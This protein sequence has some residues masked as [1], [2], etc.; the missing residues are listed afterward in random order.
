MRSYP[1]RQQKPQKEPLARPSGIYARDVNRTV[2]DLPVNAMGFG[3]WRRGRT[4][5]RELNVNS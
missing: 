2:P 4:G 5:A 3:K 1:R